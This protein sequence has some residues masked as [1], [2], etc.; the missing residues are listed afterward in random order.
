M[1]WYLLTPKE[2]FELSGYK[3]GVRQMAWLKAQKLP[4]TRGPNG[5]PRVYRTDYLWHMRGTPPTEEIAI[6]LW[7]T[8][9][10]IAAVNRGLRLLRL[11]HE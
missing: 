6:P 3:Q 10:D 7:A 4:F 9:Q 2:L 8:A 11:K 5:R 1:L